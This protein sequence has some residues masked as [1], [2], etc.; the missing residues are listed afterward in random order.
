M[1]TVLLHMG[2]SKLLDSL[3]GQL[4]AIFLPFLR[5]DQNGPSCWNRPMHSV[6][7]R[8]GCQRDVPLIPHG[9]CQGLV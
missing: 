5:G 7:F 1:Y 4:S 6:A 3:N 2:V 9:C 8:A